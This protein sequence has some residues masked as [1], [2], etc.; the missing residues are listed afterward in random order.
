M[1]NFAWPHAL[2]TRHSDRGRIRAR[3]HSCQIVHL[4]FGQARQQEHEFPPY[5]IFFLTA[6][7]ECWII[8]PLSVNKISQNTRVRILALS[9][10]APLRPAKRKWN[11]IA[12]A[13]LQA[14]HSNCITSSTILKTLPPAGPPPL[15]SQPKTLPQ[16]PTLRKSLSKASSTILQLPQSPKSYS[17]RTCRSPPTSGHR[18]FEAASR[19]RDTRA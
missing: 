8:H 13:L 11:T 15:A 6:H 14:P 7:Q 1:C 3:Q 18:G 17:L 4:T 2:L 5:P 9:S 10:S 19:G 16:S 12:I